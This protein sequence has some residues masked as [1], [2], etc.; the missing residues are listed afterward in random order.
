MR[1]VYEDSGPFWR[2][3]CDMLAAEAFDITEDEVL[4]ERDEVRET[5]LR[6]LRNTNVGDGGEFV[7]VMA[8]SQ[9]ARVVTGLLLYI[10]KMR[11]EGRLAKLGLPELKF[12]VINSATYPPLF[13]DSETESWVTGGKLIETSPNASETALSAGETWLP[14]NKKAKVIIPTLHLHG[15]TDPWRPESEKMKVE[16]FT[17]S[18]STIIEYTGGHQV[19]VREQDT[20]KII[21]A[22]RNL[23]AQTKAA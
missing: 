1:P 19:P 11:R 9:G 22:M 14:P 15:S 23:A 20:S 16:F 7:G 17:E 10:E 21:I 3:Q 13:L 5:V 18:E 8:F 12:A 6:M 2:W 4:A